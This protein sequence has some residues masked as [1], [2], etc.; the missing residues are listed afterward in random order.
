MIYSLFV[1]LIWFP[2]LPLMSV[3]ELWAQRD[4]RL[5]LMWSQ[6]QSADVGVQRNVHHAHFRQR[7]FDKPAW[8]YLFKGRQP[9]IFCFSIFQNIL[10]T[11]KDNFSDVVFR[12]SWKV[13]ISFTPINNPM[14]MF[15]FTPKLRYVCIIYLDLCFD[16]QLIIWVHFQAENAKHCTFP[17]S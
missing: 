2:S 3:D 7:K 1:S 8:S 6:Q 5:W 14:C 12:C 10:G 9:R 16:N 15:F 17:S 4:H 13:M 11:I